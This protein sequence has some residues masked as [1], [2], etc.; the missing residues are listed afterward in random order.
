MKFLISPSNYCMHS[1]AN[2]CFTAFYMY[3]RLTRHLRWTMFEFG[4]FCPSVDC[5]TPGCFKRACWYHAIPNWGRCR[6]QHRR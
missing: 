3:T 6:S 2:Y 1:T 4:F 5:P